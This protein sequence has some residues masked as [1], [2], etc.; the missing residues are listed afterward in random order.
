MSKKTDVT[1]DIALLD[2]MQSAGAGMA[3]ICFNLS[4][5]GYLPPSVRQSMKTG[6]MQWDTA[7]RA[8]RLAIAKQE[9]QTE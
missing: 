3:N 9:G 5:E 6:Q 2:D 7:L 4:Q 1:I 8:V